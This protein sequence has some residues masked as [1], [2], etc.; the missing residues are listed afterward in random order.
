MEWKSINDTYEISNVGEVRNKHTGRILKPWKMG[1]YLGV[2]LG[3]KNRHY[4]HKLVANAFLIPI[5]G[6]SIV[7]HIDRDCLNNS[8]S[9][10]RW[11]DHSDNMNNKGIE[12]KARKNNAGGQHHIYED[13]YK[14]YRVKVMINGVIHY[15]YCYSLEEAQN[16]RNEIINSN[17]K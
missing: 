2:W 7:D 15:R 8:A 3:A 16:A 4:V 11:A 14:N 10:L 12:T 13:Q 1:R 6:K 5:E 9:N 17:P